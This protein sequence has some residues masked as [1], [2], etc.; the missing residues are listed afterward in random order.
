M[1]NSIFTTCIAAG[2]CLFL[3]N[4][5]SKQNSTVW[6]DSNNLGSYK[7]AKERVLWGEGVDSTLAFN[8]TK[9]LSLLDDDFVPLQDDDLQ[10]NS[11]EIVFAQP[12]VSPGEDNSLLPGIQGFQIPKGALAAI[13]HSVYFNTDEFSVKDPNSLATIQKIAAYLERHPNTS[14][15]IEGHCDQRGAEAYNLSL[16]SKRAN[17]IRNLLIQQGVNQEQLHTISYGKE[18]PASSENTPE[19]WSKNRRAQFKIFERNL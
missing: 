1:K 11:S 7:R 19:A 3:L 2:A 8:T 9:S 13:F 16:G 5:C 14:I 10:K 12:K 6:D 18:K 17:A 4:S 15:F